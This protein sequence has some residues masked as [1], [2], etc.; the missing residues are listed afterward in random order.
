M[1]TKLPSDFK[2]F[3]KLLKEHDVQY[4]LVGGFAVFFY[5]HVWTT[6]DIDFWIR[7]DLENGTKLIGLLGEFGFP[8]HSLTPA[9]FLDQDLLVRMGVPPLRIEIFTSLSGIEFDSSFARSQLVKLDDVDVRV[10]G[11]EDLKLNKKAT[12]RLKDLDDLEHLP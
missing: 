7:P 10:I 2:E 5:G 8:T 4:M 1:A 11:L 3:L 6:S 12:G 9:S